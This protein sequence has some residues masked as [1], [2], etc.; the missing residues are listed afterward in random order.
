MDSAGYRHGRAAGWEIAQG[1]GGA[2]AEN[3]WAVHTPGRKA[4]IVPGLF[5]AAFFRGAAFLEAGFLFRRWNGKT[6]T[7]TDSRTRFRTAFNFHSIPRIIC[8]L[9]TERNGAVAQLGERRVRNAKVGSSILLG[10]TNS[11]IGPGGGTP[12]AAWSVLQASDC[13]RRVLSAI[14][15]KSVNLPAWQER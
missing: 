2:G 12:I 1:M 7:A 6:T 5:C 10:S 3:G 8:L 13:C 9:R 15:P 14:A 4:I 11:L